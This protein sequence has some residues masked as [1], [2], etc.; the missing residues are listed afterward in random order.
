M[1]GRN[2]V[3][4]TAGA[5][6][7]AAVLAVLSV[8]EEILGHR[9]V[10]ADPDHL[11]SDATLSA[12]G[13]A[14]GAALYRQYCLECH[15]SGGAGDSRAGVPDLTDGDWLYGEGRVSEIENI[16]EHGIRAH[17]PK[18]LDLAD[19]PAYARPQPSAREPQL[20][21]LSPSDILDV[22]EYLFALG[23]RPH[24]ED[25]AARGREIYAGRGACY[26]C[27]SSDARGDGAI[28]APNLT[29]GIWL[30]GDGSRADLSDTLEHGRRGVCPAWGRRLGAKAIRELAVY[31]Y[32]LSHRRPR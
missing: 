15:R 18:T 1:T 31:V 8:R 16:I 28:G 2:S 27:H 4:M 30:Y 5:T 32:T 10:V 21:P 14:R 7:F 24:A 19:M 29:D 25:A 22:T 17:A 23:R 3:W 6:C 11:P 12:Y 26:D 20:R 9:L 13:A